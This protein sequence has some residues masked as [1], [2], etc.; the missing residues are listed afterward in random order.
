MYKKIVL[1]AAFIISTAAAFSQANP[2]IEK[3]LRDPN[4]TSNEAKADVYVQSK[5][6]TD[7]VQHTV[8]S[9]SK[10]IRKKR[11]KKHKVHA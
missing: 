6:I 7:T 10:T 11:P 2:R 3:A 4:R 8:I 5:T 9:D 1:F